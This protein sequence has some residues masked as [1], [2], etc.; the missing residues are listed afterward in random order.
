MASDDP[1]DA[2]DHSMGGGLYAKADPSALVVPPGLV[3]STR[4]VDW[5]VARRLYAPTLIVNL[6]LLGVVTVLRP[7]GGTLKATWTYSDGR[8]VE[9]THPGFNWPF[10][11]TSV[12]LSLHAGFLASHRYNKALVVACFMDF[13]TLFVLMNLVQWA[14]ALVAG[15][16][17]TYEHDMDAEHVA[18]LIISYVAL[19]PALILLG[20]ADA[21]EMRRRDKIMLYGAGVLYY[22]FQRISTEVADNLFLEEGRCL[23]HMACSSVKTLA[24]GANTNLI[25][26]LLKAVV[27]TYRH[28]PFAFLAP[29][30]AYGHASM[31][32]GAV[33]NAAAAHRVLEE[34]ATRSNDLIQY[35]PGAEILPRPY[36]DRMAGSSAAKGGAAP[37][38]LKK[39]PDAE[40][41][42]QS[43]QARPADTA[44]I[45]PI[46]AGGT[47][48][49]LRVEPAIPN[50]AS[51]QAALAKWVHTIELLR[52]WRGSALLLARCDELSCE[53]AQARAAPA[54]TRYGQHDQDQKTLWADRKSVV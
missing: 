16:L 54:P 8:V 44:A 7:G 36:D 32:Q 17:S 40:E 2:H 49:A 42:E 48:D 20:C 51:R 47:A 19:A 9:F 53:L 52:S 39:Q 31:H 12:V 25:V 29:T 1:P 11:L 50:T 24:V 22:G 41:G 27:S 37:A 33:H 43:D 34:H 26:F 35:A 23:H 15:F 46:S 5:L 45:G 6:L 28:R 18:G 21:C 3:C 30:F 38:T 10:M 13:S 14:F 4:Y